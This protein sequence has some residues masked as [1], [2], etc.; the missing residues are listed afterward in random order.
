[1]F[2]IAWKR[3]LELQLWYQAIGYCCCPSFTHISAVFSA[4]LIPGT[5]SNSGRTAVPAVG[6]SLAVGFQK[7]QVVPDLTQ[8]RL[9]LLG[10]FGDE[11]WL[12]R[13]VLGTPHPC[14]A[15]KPAFAWRSQSRRMIRRGRRGPWTVGTSLSHPSAGFLGP[16]DSAST[17]PGLVKVSSDLLPGFS[18]DGE[19][20]ARSGGSQRRISEPTSLIS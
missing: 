6:S 4:S 13:P 2:P 5:E 15:A 8:Q 11:K 17:F 19:G 3:L 14:P 7:V 18:G 9:G 16:H 1:M 10:D 20:V 12:D